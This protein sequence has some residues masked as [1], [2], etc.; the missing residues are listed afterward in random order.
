MPS[1]EILFLSKDD[2]DSLNLGLKDIFDVIELGLKAH[3]EKQ[4]IMPSKDHLV[5]DY[6]E[7][8]F[9]ILKGYVALQN[10]ER[11]GYQWRNRL[12]CR[13]LYPATANSFQ[14]KKKCKVIA[15]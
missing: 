11:T 3:G 15:P 5:L 12:S 14:I 6:P 4:V 2:I 9:N 10:P 8:L 7:R 13:I 1:I